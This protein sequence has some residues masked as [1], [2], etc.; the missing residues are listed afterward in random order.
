MR[1]VRSL[2]TGPDVRIPPAAE[3]RDQ[4]LAAIV[5]VS[6]SVEVI[7]RPELSWRPAALALGGALAVAVLVRR[8]RVLAAVALSFG[9]FLGFDVAA[10]VFQAEPVVLYTGMVVLVLVYSLYRWGVGRDIVMG[11]LLVLI[12]Y[13]VAILTDSSG[14]GDA[15]GGAAVLIC[16]AALGLAWRYRAEARERLVEQAKLHERE[17]IARELHDSVAHHVSAIA[18]QAQAGL[19]LA[20]SGSPA[21]ATDALGIIDRE[22]AEA[23]AEMRTVVA[24]LRD[25]Q[26]SSRL[27]PHHGLADIKRLAAATTG[28][29]D[30]EVE[31]CGDLT[32]LAPPFEAALYRVSQESVTNARRHAPGVTRV[33]VTVTGNAADVQLTVLDDGARTATSNA[34][35]YGLVGM[36]ERVALLGGTL[37]A[38]PGAQ[39]GWLV[40]AV[41]PRP[42]GMT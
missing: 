19:V 37:S 41:L 31:L 26:D 35:G 16:A 2:W 25:R 12:E 7:T 5:L 15:L 42:K 36:S 24:G 20:R 9:A 3:R 38:G 29:L 13:A 1:T 11:T 6:A 40:R 8:T 4:I 23:L 21:G 32:D 30:V 39:G 10:A 33:A 34:P 18:T 14:A 22:A 28:S 27:A 17:L